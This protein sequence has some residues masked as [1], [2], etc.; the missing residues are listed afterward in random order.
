MKGREREKAQL[1][2]GNRG[3]CLPELGFSSQRHEGGSLSFPPTDNL[4]RQLAT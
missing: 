2:A 4:S 1:S 3:R